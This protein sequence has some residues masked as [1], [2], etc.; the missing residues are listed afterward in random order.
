MIELN[1]IYKSYKQR[2]VSIDSRNSSFFLS[3]LLPKRHIDLTKLATN[4]NHFDDLE[5]G[6]IESKSITLSKLEIDKD[7]LL[8]IFT[9]YEED[10][11]ETVR[12]IIPTFKDS[13]FEYYE[14]LLD[15]R[16]SDIKIELF[17]KQLLSNYESDSL[18]LIQQFSRLDKQ[19]KAIERDIGK[20]DLYLGFPFIEGK[21]QNGKNFRGPLILQR[22][23]L[24]D[25]SDS[26]KIDIQS[27]GKIINPVFLLS[28]LN[29]N[30]KEYRRFEFEIPDQ[31]ED[32]IEYTMDFLN[33]NNINIRKVQKR[34]EVIES[35]TKSEYEKKYFN[36]I[37][38]FDIKFYAVLGLFPIS[39]RSIYD[40][41]D[42]LDKNPKK[43][44]ETLENFFNGYK[45]FDDEF[46]DKTPKESM[47]KYISPL[48]WSQRIVVKNALE[49]DL[50][51]EGPPGTGKSQTIVNIIVN[52]LLQNKK[53]LV[54][55]EKLAA[56][57]V[58]YN[59]LGKLRENTL[60]IKD[61]IRNKEDFFKQIIDTKS[62]LNNYD[63]TYSYNHYSD[64]VIDEYLGVLKKINKKEYY[65]GKS[66]NELIEFTKKHK[67]YSLSIEQNIILKKL[68]NFYVSKKKSIDD[69]VLRLTYL[70]SSVTLDK[71][72]FFL[73]M[74]NTEI[75]K[76]LGFQGI[77]F[78]STQTEANQRKEFIQ[79]N[80]YLSKTNK[81]LIDRFDDVCFNA[82]LEPRI[83]TYTALE[84]YVN[85]LYAKINLHKKSLLKITDP[86]YAELSFDKKKVDIAIQYPNINRNELALR[87]KR[88]KEPNYNQTF[89]Q[90]L[91]RKPI[92]LSNEE[93]N[94]KEYLENYGDVIDRLA[95]KE[96]H[97]D[98]LKVDI[99]IANEYLNRNYNSV[100]SLFGML[101]NS[102]L[103]QFKDGSF[104]RVF[105][106]YKSS[107]T[108][109]NISVYNEM[110]SLIEEEILYIEK[111]NNLPVNDDDFKQFIQYLNIDH[112]TLNELIMIESYLQAFDSNYKNVTNSLNDKYNDSLNM[113]YNHMKKSLNQVFR[114]NNDLYR[115]YNAL[116]GQAELKR[117]KS[118][119]TIFDRYGKPI[120]S[121]F[122]VI[123]MTPEVVSTAFPMQEGLF[124]YV[125]FDEASQMFI[126]RAVP[127]IHRA[128]R[129]I[130]AGDSKQLKPSSTFQ[131]RLAESEELDDDENVTNLELEALDKESLLEMAKEKYTS[132]MIQFHYRS[133]HEEL[134]EF[135]SAAFYEGKL[136]FASKINGGKWKKPIEIVKVSDG[137][138]TS[139]NTNP[140]EAESVVKIVS[141]LLNKRKF[142]ETIGIITFNIKQKELIQDML[143]ES[144][145]RLI[146]LEL[147]RV[148]PQTGDDEGLFVKNIENVQGDERDIIIF[149]IG[150]AKNKD[151]RVR[152]QFGL[153]NQS[154][155]ENRLNV[156]IT[157]AKKKIIVVKSIESDELQV[158]EHIPGPTRLKQ[159]LK[160]VELVHSQKSEDKKILL[161]SICD[162]SSIFH[163]KIQ[164]FDSPFELEVFQEISRIKPSN[165]E[166]RNQVNVGGFLID[167]ALYDKDLN[168][169]ILGIECDG[170]QYHSKPE[171]VER[172]FHRQQ[173][174][175]SRGWQIHRIISTNW[176]R[177]KLSEV[178]VVKTLMGST[179]S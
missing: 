100:S 118:I 163:E 160:F 54:V 114:Y 55:S 110:S 71:L 117:R 102:D 27:E 56:I 139:E 82:G 63:E 120:L 147:N 22:V 167:I 4:L 175:E 161:N 34:F 135:S 14:K 116:I 36:D 91:F 51:I 59:R 77:Q 66:I 39:S 33:K 143:L 155:G 93:E 13:D 81:P 9:N 42:Y 62:T 99:V 140:V 128:K 136:F 8:E 70:S 95:L 37:N 28:Y 97:G 44:S 176:F 124:D 57:E 23:S 46:D 111:C 79:Y 144:D 15:K 123:L 164:T 75:F 122:P 146:N 7:E 30:G 159:Y 29:E 17:I 141:Q 107:L 129:V 61:Y 67:N 1:S 85:N 154:G 48:D 89:I 173:Y 169:F 20:N 41:L 156:A 126:E 84:T 80:Y 148:N 177:D 106:L 171:D 92:E 19:A 152:A 145:N 179:V 133:E 109:I 64:T 121:I 134:I 12:E 174:L 6:L 21:F 50:V 43:S 5:N 138:W 3:K 26:V 52:L 166:L 74:K 69:Q 150:Y 87:I 31:S 178:E 125:I 149:S 96:I 98:M 45:N 131:A 172:D 88:L 130:I 115:E 24:T 35:L 86:L 11:R 168:K 132:K 78:F 113:V 60:I 112:H 151:G 53:V 2:L 157:R 94:F 108:S 32:Y 47:I 165:I 170:Y 162:S 127:A 49:K 68:I 142:N 90:K 104:D 58:V 153:L 10:Y 137:L 119:K 83:F 73:S 76:T 16:E 40:D 18:K 25:Y 105:D 101:L 72:E 65:Q 158:N 103:V 38:K